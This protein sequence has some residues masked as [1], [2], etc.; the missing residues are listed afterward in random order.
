MSDALQHS[1]AR[2]IRTTPLRDVLRG[3]LTGRLDVRARI[4]TSG[5]PAPAQALVARLVRRT[6][7]SRLE[8]V[9]VADEL[10]AHF[11]DGIGAGESVDAL[12]ASFGDE[13]RAAR[14]IGRAKRRARPWPWHAVRALEWLL[15]GLLVVYVI[16]AV[17]FY[18][19]SP[20]TSADYVAA[21]NAT[22]L[23]TPADKRAWPVY[24]EAL[25]KLEGR[26]ERQADRKLWYR[27]SA[28]PGMKGWP[29]VVAWLERNAGA[30][31][32]MRRAAAKPA[33][34]FVLGPN[35]SADD[36]E[37]WPPGSEADRDAKVYEWLIPPEPHLSELRLAAT[38][39]AADAVLARERGDRPRLLADLAALHDL[40][41][42]LGREQRAMPQIIALGLRAS[43]IQ[44]LDR[45]LARRPDLFTDDDLRDL[46]HRIAAPQTAADLLQFD[47]ERARFRHLLARAYTDDG[48]GGGRL[49]PAGLRALTDDFRFNPTP[50]F[51]HDTLGRLVGPAAIL[52][53]PGR[54]AQRAK[55]DQLFEAGLASLRVPL[56]EAG[57]DPDVEAFVNS[58]AARLRYLPVHLTLT[59]AERF[60]LSAERYLGARD[61][62]LV[63][64]ALELHRR[65]AGQYPVTLNELT[66]GLLPEVPVDR[67]SGKPVRYR[68]GDGRPLVYSLGGDGDDDQGRV[69]AYP[70]GQINT[71]GAAQWNAPEYTFDGD[72]VL[73]PDPT[74]EVWH[75]ETVEED[76]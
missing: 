40:A 14:L 37:L 22:T 8:R 57:P 30:L 15:V 10:I 76:E 20:S 12:I 74:P 69:P 56:R 44:E 48:R 6:R 9:D 43:E 63:G 4:E 2:K 33:L 70:T 73:Y 23:Q 17:V 29:D 5:L 27:L 47:D 28:R 45:A 19:G 58:G 54:A 59:Y 42:Q 75:E 38:A 1:L 51:P 39:L 25:L 41:E 72:W 32:R 36:P 11:V 50:G 35:G 18:T 3:R 46:A 62:V 24:R 49:T 34:G 26:H 71:W 7:L 21:L 68:L 66:P 16:A 31:E 64:M 61:G 67:I 13:R 65:R 53:T 60:R 55:F 52:L